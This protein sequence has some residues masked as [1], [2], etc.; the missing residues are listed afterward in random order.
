MEQ[1]RGMAAIH[2]H[3]PLAV[4]PLTV[5]EALRLTKA[6]G[7]V[8]ILNP[9]PAHP[10]PERTLSLV[11]ILTPNEVKARLGPSPGSVLGTRR[12]PPGPPGSF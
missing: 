6:H 5:R 2:L 4:R 3:D 9:A 10:L 8:T 7:L 1:V 12:R 11:D